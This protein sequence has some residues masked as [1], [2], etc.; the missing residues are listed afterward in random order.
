[1]VN[2]PRSN[3]RRDWIL[4]ATVLLSAW[5][6]FQVQPMAG[7]R[8]LPWFGGGP[9]VWTTAMLFFQAALLGGYLYAHLSSRYLRPAA[10]A[11]LHALLLV[12]AVAVLV[13]NGVI[14]GDVWKPIGSDGPIV[15]ILSILAGTVGLP[16]LLLA[17]TAPLVQSWW[18]RTHS[19]GSP[20]RLYALSNFGSL[21]ALVSYPIAVE[22]ALGLGT[23]GAIWAATFAVFAAFCATS[24]LISTR[25]LPLPLGEGRGEGEAPTAPR[26][27]PH[28]PPSTYSLQPTAYSLSP[29]D[30]FLWLA[31]PAC[32]SALLLAATNYLCQDV[33][34][35]PLLWIAPLA[36]YLLTFII[37]FD[38][39]RWY[40]RDIWYP[41]LV[42][43]SFAAVWSWIEGASLELGW[44]VAVHLLLVF[45]VGMV[46]HGEAARRRP[47]SAHLTSFYLC[48]ALGGA[49]GGLFVA[50]IAP[51]TFADYY[52]LPLTVLA[53]WVLAGF[54]V[55]TDPRSPLCFK[56][57][58]WKPPALP[59]D[60]SLATAQDRSESTGRAGGFYSVPQF[61]ALA[62]FAIV[63]TALAVL[64]YKSFTRS[65]AEQVA[66]AR[67]FFGVLKVTQRAPD[68]G[69][70][71]LRKL[72]N[73]RISHGAQYVG[74]TGRT[75]PITYYARESGVG[76]ALAGPAA[77]PRNIG[78]VGLGS[79]TIA[80]Y[81]ESGDALRFYDINPQVI[82]FADEYFTYLE[83]AR[84]RGATV[85][86]LQGDARLVL[87]REDAQHFDVLALDAF[88]GDAI[89]M[90]LLTLEAVELY[91]RHLR[92]PGGVLAVH[93]SNKHLNLAPVVLAAAERFNL[94]GWIVSNKDDDARA[95][96]S[97]TWILLARP[98]QA[99]FAKWGDPLD[100]ENAAGPSIPWT[101]DHSSLWSVLKD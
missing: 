7:K 38:A 55:A 18:G 70:P 39:D 66:R 17:S 56:A 82:T 52:E 8:I 79:G 65:T 75:E 44:Q 21:A 11:I 76:R 93:I 98:G 78:V 15:G 71:I 92:D 49:L 2:T 9:A 29:R 67:N 95:I 64:S 36:L 23:Q 83:D 99:N 48:L 86:V 5:L 101:D 28:A 27:Y 54:V 85:D 96:E 45:A 34:S 50:V 35:L 26:S 94:D 59:V 61:F 47:G 58:S 19:V 33:A 37:A 1:V 60:S 89:P 72:L 16:Y 12:A 100:A 10:Q 4:S 68:D 73:G 24:A 46:C 3:R 80:V 84:R 53:A 77:V 87:E 57:F 81:A 97:S 91:L 74:S 25:V 69:G 30:I 90:H 51:L 22:P 14:A 63:A 13:A 31:L 20:Y 40:R 41:A 6:L 32:A 43:T 62:A 88:S 42:L